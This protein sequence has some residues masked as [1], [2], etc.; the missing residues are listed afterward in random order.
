M[1][2]IS[3]IKSI[4][5]NEVVALVTITSLSLSFLYVFQYGLR[6]VLSKQ[7]AIKEKGFL[8]QIVPP[9]YQ[10]DEMQDVR[11]VRFA[12]QRFFDDL[13]AST[14]NQRISFEISSNKSGINFLVWTP[15]KKMQ[16]LIKQSLQTTYQ[17]RI[18]FIELETDMLSG[19][20]KYNSKCSEYKTL[21]HSVYLLMD[22]KDFDAVDPVEGILN[23]MTGLKGDEKMYFQVVLSPAKR[24]MRAIA[25]AKENFRVKKSDIT[26]SYMFFRRF[27]SYLLYFIPL[28]PF[29]FIMLISEIMKLGGSKQSLDPILS[30]PDSDPRKV[31]AQSEEVDDF[32]KQ[33]N[34]KFKTPFYSY[35]R[36]LVSGGDE[37]QKMEQFDQALETMK[38][39]SLNS[40][41]RKNKNR[42]S[43][44]QS[45]Y[46]YPEDELFPFYKELFTSQ[47]TLSSREVSM[48]YHFPSQIIDPTVESFVFVNVASK[49]SFRKQQD[50][51]DLLLGNN[52]IGDKN[53]KVFLTTENRKRHMVIT[54][55]TGTGKSTI[56]KNFV[57]Q[58]I[59]NRIFNG[60][61]R[62][63]ILMDPH[64]DFF[65]DILFKLHKS[66]SYSKELI[67][68]DTRSEDFF[69]GF[70]PLYSVG[71]SE[72]EIDMV[73]DANYEFIEKLIKKVNP[74][75][76]MGVTAKPMLR[77]SM[78]TLMIFQNEWILKNGNSDESIALM[79]RFAPTLNEIKRLFFEVDVKER[80]LKWIDFD[81]YQ[82]L[83]SFWNATLPN[84]MSSP[85]WNDIRQAFDNKLS[86]ILSGSLYYTFSQSQ[87]SIEISE[88]IR[89]SKILL[90]NLSSKN[91]GVDGMQLLGSL[92][93]SKLWF[94]S[95]R[96]EQ[97]D[98]RPFVIYADEFQNFANS[99]F[100]VALSEA[101]KFK[102]ELVL[103]HQFFAQLPKEVKDAVTGNVKSRIYY[104]AGL[105]DA[106]EIADDLQ[107]KVLQE[108]I[109]EIPEFHSYVRVGEDVF[110]I[111]VPKERDNNWNAEFV[112]N[113]VDDSY[114][115]IGRS[116]L[117]VVSEMKLRQ[118]WYTNGCPVDSE[119]TQ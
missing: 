38:S 80:I 82:G 30:L 111:S 8:M 46:I 102:L 53:H 107:G 43:D 118:S 78:K 56:L 7:R 52:T 10:T 49:E 105:D 90:V 81:K 13:T 11:G 72:R 5:E 103:A 50:K 48:I 98:R 6:V 41:V 76:G 33:L 20:N 14:K 36:V 95:K 2:T 68:W 37:N 100:A 106:E 25:K 70:N 22:L 112:E 65:I 75:G 60:V 104:R 1:E 92:L 45:R 67:I 18:K 79:K 54:G 12:L 39:T 47:T 109:M 17:H 119:V 19:F 59:D 63:L 28:L 85:A 89:K 73:V 117:Q 84:Y 21:K 15:T 110:S 26:W 94:E 74:E 9:K 77:N 42:L 71:L 29:M 83:E 96:I 93:M 101:R 32:N 108:E 86:Q 66:F 64:E 99:D 3:F 97:E 44:M 55:Q 40:L 88:C 27:E 4:L 23:S 69:L 115:K 34:E 116:K 51:S 62:G 16:S 58:D 87:N 35:I 57:L 114:Q 91:I 24:D 113:L 61:K 31:L